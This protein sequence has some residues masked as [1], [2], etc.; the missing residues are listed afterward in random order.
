MREKRV[1]MTMINI[2]KGNFMKITVV[3]SAIIALLSTLSGCGGSAKEKETPRLQSNVVVGANTDAS[4]T[5]PSAGRNDGDA[6]DAKP[7]NPT[8]SMAPNSNMMRGST[9]RDDV[10]PGSKAAN[11]NRVNSRRDADDR[12][13]KDSDGDDDD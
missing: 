7:M 5:N 13:K 4:N 1:V 6:D 2:K 9:D 12:G 11:S 10:R 8:R 3:L